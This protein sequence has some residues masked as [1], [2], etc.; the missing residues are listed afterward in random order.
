MPPKRKHSIKKVGT[1]KFDASTND[2]IPLSEPGLTDA[3]LRAAAIAVTTTATPVSDTPEFF[4]D[5]SFV[6][7][8]SPVTLDLNTALG[9]NATTALILNDGPGSFT[10]QLSVDGAAFGDAITLKQREFKQYVD[11]S[12]D[13]IRI[14]WVADSAYR[15]EAI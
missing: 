13:S 9:R 15:V 2:W 10:Y 1:Y 3:E 8:D 5:T 7:G 11:V 6:T 12:I 14:T 4:E